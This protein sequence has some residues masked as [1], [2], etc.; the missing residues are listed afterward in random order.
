M[1]IYNCPKCNIPIRKSNTHNMYFCTNEKCR[2]FYLE[3]SV[4]TEFSKLLFS[5]N[6]YGKSTNYYFCVEVKPNEIITSFDSD[7]IGIKANK[8]IVNNLKNLIN[9]ETYN[10]IE[11]VEDVIECYKI[12]DNYI[13]KFIKNIVFM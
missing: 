3:F 10:S 9:E 1:K 5:S 8:T 2:R 6:V 11:S 12:I 13:C 4:D 7:F